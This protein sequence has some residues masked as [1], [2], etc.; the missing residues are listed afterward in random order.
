MHL[1]LKDKKIILASHVH[2]TGPAHDLLEY[3]LQEKVGK[4]LFITH[5]LFPSA[6]SGGSGFQLF[7]KGKQ[8]SVHE[9]SRKKIPL[10]VAYI[11]AVWLNIWWSIK[12]DKH[13]TMYIGS[14]NL[15]AFAGI[16]LKKMGYVDKVIFWVIDYNPNRFS[17]FFLNKIY[18]VLDRICVRHCD[19]TWNLSVRMEEGRKQYFNFSGGNQRVV[20]VGIWFDR[21]QRVHT[22]DTDRTNTL[23]FMGHILEKQGVQYVLQAMPEIL[24]K[25]PAFQFLVIGDGEY[26]SELKK[27]ASSLGIEKSV[28]FTGYIDDH[29]DIENMLVQCTAAVALYEKYD[30]DGNLTFTYFADPAKIKSYLA[31][32]LPVLTTDVSHNAKDIEKE[33]CGF[34]VPLERKIIA[35]KIIHLLKN[36][37]LWREYHDNAIRYAQKFDWKVIFDKQFDRLL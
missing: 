30:K 2:A 37:D 22:Q 14:N 29:R 3:F 19:E 11:R 4:V 12:N 20:P 24:E 34:I 28:R 7:Q 31:S 8:V 16:L 32:G 35:K 1:K 21:I 27:L 25:L 26:L 5:P 9:N 13:Y 15:N 17:N 33:R 23:V 36:E 10:I 6:K 18:H